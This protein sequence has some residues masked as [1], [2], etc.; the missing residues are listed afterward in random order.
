MHVSSVFVGDVGTTMD[1]NGRSDVFSRGIS[2]N[3]N[4]LVGAKRRWILLAT[5]LLALSPKL[6][7]KVE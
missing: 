4:R 7:I 2:G 5:T 1:S 3:D 6:V